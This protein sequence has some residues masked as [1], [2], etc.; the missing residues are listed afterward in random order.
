MDKPKL[1]IGKIINV[2]GLQGELKIASLTDFPLLRYRKGNTVYLEKN[3]QYLPL[4]VKDAHHQP[5][6]DYVQFVG[7]L[8]INLVKDWVQLYLY[9]DKENI[10]LKPG[11]FFYEDLMG[12]SIEDDQGQTLGKV[13]ALDRIGNRINLRMAR[14]SQADVL[15]PFIDVFIKHVNTEKKVIT[16]TLIEGML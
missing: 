16:V 15:I 5:G 7:Y 4:I 14:G 12:M 9:A 10:R 13:I 6:T 2:R 1:T 3:G 8:D 11:N